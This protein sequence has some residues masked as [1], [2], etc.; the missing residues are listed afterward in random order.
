MNASLASE[1]W[2]FLKFQVKY[3]TLAKHIKNEECL[4][5]LKVW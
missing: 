5:E 3:V 2:N 4:I 1:H